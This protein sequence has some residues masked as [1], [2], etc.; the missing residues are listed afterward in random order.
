MVYHMKM[1]WKWALVLLAACA[2]LYLFL[3]PRETAEDI[4]ACRAWS[5]G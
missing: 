5:A 1:L 4:P 2:A 3:R